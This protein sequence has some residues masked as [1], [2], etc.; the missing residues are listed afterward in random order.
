MF[1]RVAL[2]VAMKEEG[3]GLVSQL[4]L[5][6][7]LA[8]AP[9]AFPYFFGSYGNCLELHLF[10]HSE[11]PRYHVPEV[12]L[13]PAAVCAYH[14]V[15]QVRP[16][17]LINFGTAGCFL[18]SGLKMGEVCFIDSPIFFHDRRVPLKR[19][20]ESQEGGY[21][22]VDLSKLKTKL[23]LRAMRLSSGSSLEMSERDREMLIQ[24][25]A[26]LKEMEAA[27]I[28]WVC[29]RS[30][31]PFLA[32]K[33]V[34][35]FIDTKE[36]ITKQFLKNLSTTSKNLQEVVVEVLKYLDEN[37]ND[38]LWTFKETFKEN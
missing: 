17:L 37:P 33:G 7:G 38:P 21:N 28:A 36:P 12:G 9:I 22:T 4:K 18:E 13:E 15:T 27:A 35:D 34:T 5:T 16:H 32:I 24:Q 3:I 31:T 25:G 1:R 2:Q 10:F 20:L 19:F 11:D 30:N 26:H 14:I 8:N 6:Q 29:Y 23:G